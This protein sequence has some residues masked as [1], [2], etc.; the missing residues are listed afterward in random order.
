MRDFQKLLVIRPTNACAGT[1]SGGHWHASVGRPA[2]PH[3]VYQVLYARGLEREAARR[4]GQHAL[5]GFL[6]SIFPE[7]RIRLR[8]DRSREPQHALGVKRAPRSRSTPPVPCPPRNSRDLLVGHLIRFAVG[9]GAARGVLRRE[10][11]NTHGIAVASRLFE[12]V[13][14]RCRCRDGRRPGRI[15]GMCRRGIRGPLHRARC[16]PLCFRRLAVLLS[17]P[18]GLP[19]PFP[20]TSKS[21]TRRRFLRAMKRFPSQATK[22]PSW[23]LL[24]TVATSRL[25]PTCSP[26]L[27]A[28]RLPACW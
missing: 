1:T 6:A 9:E 2:K 3:A 15:D 10:K 4:L 16:A 22:L 20:P 28:T 25:C 14:S 13:G 21:S 26:T 23:R 5:A 7:T 18:R 11:G 12:G 19:M 24:H 8:N 17:P 27:R